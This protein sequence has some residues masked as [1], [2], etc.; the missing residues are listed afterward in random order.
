V[1]IPLYENGTAFE[2]RQLDQDHPENGAEFAAL[3]PLA[4][5]PLLVDI[6]RAIVESSVI[7]EYLD[8]HHPGLRRDDSP[9][10]SRP[11]GPL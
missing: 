5:M 3:W 1:L 9:L 8:L 2:F 11:L 6:G 4:K 7:I 10:P